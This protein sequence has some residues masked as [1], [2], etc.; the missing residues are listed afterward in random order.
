MAPKK[1]K[2]IQASKPTN[3]RKSVG[4]VKT[5][6]DCGSV[7]L[8]TA[9]CIR[10]DQCKKSFHCVCKNIEERLCRKLNRDKTPWLC[11]ECE[12]ADD[13]GEDDEEEIDTETTMQQTLDAIRKQLSVLEAKCNDMTVLKKKVNEISTSQQFLSESYDDISTQLTKV[14]EENKNLRNDVNALTKKCSFLTKELEHMK[15]K[16]N[17]HEQEKLSSNVLI[18]GVQANEEPLAAVK[19]IATMVEMQNELD[20]VVTAKQITYENRD[21]AIVA[22]FTDD[23]VKT[24]FV[25]AAK[26][27]RIG[28]KMFGYAGDN[29]PVYVDEQLTRETF[30]LF[31]YAKQQLKHNGCQF[32]WISNGDILTRIEPSS[33]CVKITHKRQVDEIEKTLL[34]NKRQQ[35]HEHNANMNTRGEQS[36]ANVQNV[37][38]RDNDKNPNLGGK[39]H[40]SDRNA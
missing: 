11:E 19:K 13:D 22:N 21:P 26:K 30:S 15:S 18:R 34:L 20:N 33:P 32:V 29:K 9:I 38:S 8:P 39:K 31:K 16:V 23:N 40:R 10:C 35:N 2:D 25:K 27:K 24:K 37:K 36:N 3:N 28:T 7:I 6:G 12:V 5:C 1:P 4:P 17:M 14:T